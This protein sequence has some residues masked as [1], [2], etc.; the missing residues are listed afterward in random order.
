MDAIFKI[1]LT[2]A[3]VAAVLGFLAALATRHWKNPHVGYAL[4]LIVLLRL[5]APPLLPMSI[6]IPAWATSPFDALSQNSPDLGIQRTH[7]TSA[8]PVLADPAP[9]RAIG[10]G[11]ISSRPAPAG[12]TNAVTNQ[13]TEPVPA[14]TT[15]S[16]PAH[17]PA[18]GLHFSIRPL[19]VGLWIAG[20]LVYLLLV[21]FR[22]RRF[23][24]MIQRASR[25]T[26]DP[27]RAEVAAIAAKIGLLIE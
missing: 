22:A 18:A 24:R 13:R 5:V 8:A 27:L 17:A 3:A 4:W 19:V 23:S 26:P 20:T 2:N 14:E 25:E 9:P 11:P 21:T 15:S 10:S 12:V 6:S 1:G 7:D 16:L